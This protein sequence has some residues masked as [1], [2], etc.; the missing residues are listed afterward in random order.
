MAVST[1]F[2]NFTLDQLSNWSEVHIKRMFGCV[3][4]FSDGLMFGLVSKDAIFFK[5][6]ETNKAKYLKAGSEPLRLFKN[7]SMVASFYEVPLDV[8][9]DSNKLTVW[10]KES[11]EVQKKIKSNNHK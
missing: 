10:A 2:L 9:E 1:D 5:V 11:L 4:L 3:G 6:G 7:D 8:F